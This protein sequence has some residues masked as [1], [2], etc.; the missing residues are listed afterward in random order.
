MKAHEWIDRLKVTKNLPSDYAAAKAL[1]ITR[2]AVSNYRGRA[3]TLDEDVAEK[4][5]ILLG[6]N[7]VGIVLDQAAE[8]TKSPALRQSLAAEAA[9]LCALC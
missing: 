2:S 3:S 9:R 5:A 1:H 7:P 8:R 4:I 6:I